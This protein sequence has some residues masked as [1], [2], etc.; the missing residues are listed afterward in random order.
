[1]SAY[2]A[3]HRFPGFFAV[4]IV[5]WMQL[6]TALHADQTLKFKVDAGQHDRSNTP[7]RLEIGVNQALRQAT[8][9]TIE[10]D[11]G[12]KVIG[13]VTE[14]SLLA[15]IGPTADNLAPRELCFILP[16]LKT[17]QSKEFTATVTAT[18]PATISPSDCFQWHDTP[19]VYDDLLFGNRP[20]LRYMYHGLD[21]SSTESRDST[22][23]VY[24]HV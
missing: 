12:N 8:W 20:V 23:K 19:G 11:Q 9:A 4:P 14:P 17:G 21:E 7:I 16:Q 6:V 5:V 3:V 24:H 18:P 13:Q 10:D 1:M 15:T 2:Q 22:F